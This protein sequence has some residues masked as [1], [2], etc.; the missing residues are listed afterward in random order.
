MFQQFW[1]WYPMANMISLAFVPTA[2][3]ALNK[4]LEMP[5]VEFV[6]N[7]KPSTFAYPAALSTHTE[8]KKEKV[9]TAVLSIT[10]KQKKKEADKKKAAE[11]AE[12]KSNAAAPE[13]SAADHDGDSKS[14]KD[15][16]PAGKPEDKP[17]DKE[18]AVE[19]E[20]STSLLQNPARVMRAQLRLVSLAPS[21]RYESLKP[22]S[23]GGIVVLRDRRPADG[24]ERL[25][26][27]V[28]AH[29][30]TSG[31]GTDGA[32]G[33]SDD[34]DLPEPEPPEAFEWTEEMEKSLG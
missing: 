1:Y 16:A 5:Q 19:A 10:A 22:V 24:D 25:V 34:G 12:G 4:N 14:S 32:G 30:P 31:A 9:E 26:E 15:A 13:A 6:C 33:S 17:S 23:Q 27:S 2:V 20:P 21:C 29:G 7:A 8:K 28:R 3:I 11:V 18:A